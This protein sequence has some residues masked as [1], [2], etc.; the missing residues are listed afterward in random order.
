[1]DAKKFL[2]ELLGAGQDLGQRGRD[3]AEQKFDLPAEG[4][5]RDAML[6]GM[7]KGAAVAGALALLLGTKSGR[8]L[9]GKAVKLGSLAALGGVAYKAYQSWQ[10]QNAAPAEPG[11]VSVDRDTADNADQRSLRLLRAMIAAA[12]ADGHIDSDER[13]RI[14]EQ[15]QQ[16][17]LDASAAEFIQGELERPLNPADIALGVSGVEE[18]AEMYLAS[19]TVLDLDN[20]MEEAYMQ[21]L[22]TALGLPTDVVAELHKQ[23]DLQ[24]A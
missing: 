22:A 14:N 2:D 16:L 9:G 3:Y 15:V 5:E 24:R 18:A 1:M 23:L 13:R 7:G 19:L 11:V 6:S 12:R 4:A 8:K 17:G 21:H 10:E 20:P